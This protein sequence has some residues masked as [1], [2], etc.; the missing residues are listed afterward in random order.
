MMTGK[1][2]G[3]LGIYGFR[4]RKGYSYELEFASSWSVHT[5]RIWDIL[6]KQEKKVVVFGVPQ[7]YPPSKVNGEMISCFL[8]PDNQSNYT[9]PTQLKYELNSKFKEYII[10]VENFRTDKKEELLHQIYKMT[11]Q[12]FSIAR[13]LIQTRDW[14]FFIMVEMGPDR[15]HHGFWKF[16]DPLHPKYNPHSKY[17]EVISDYY[18]YLDEEVGKLISLVDDETG[19]IIISDHGA[20]AMKG[21][22]CVNEWLIEQGYLSLKKVP[23]TLTPLSRCE[24]NWENTLI[25]GEGGYYSRIFFNVQQRE[26]QGKIDPKDY[27]IIRK[28]IKEKL[29]ALGDEKGRNINTKVYIPSELYREIRGYPPDLI[30]LFGDLDWRSIGSVGLK[31]IHTFENDTG[32]DDANHTQW[33][34]F[35]FNNIE[36]ATGEKYMK[37]YDIAPLVLDFFGLGY[38][39]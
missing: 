5:P 16:C 2:P 25:W 12:H 21:G 30:V 36:R 1:D 17:K 8:T 24:I 26:R 20:K 34:M 31:K 28:E 32:P 29:E 9:Y 6:S 38:L 11:E 18:K 13:Y 14:D 7:T 35:I 33:G 37:I 4:N 15:I 39:K 27:K 10:D 22:V 3:E 23:Q 19:I